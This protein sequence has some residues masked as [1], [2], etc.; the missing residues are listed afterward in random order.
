MRFALLNDH[1]IEASPGAQGVCPGCNADMLARCGAKKVWHWAHKGRRHCDHWWE[2]ETQWHRDWKN[3]FETDWQEVPARDEMGELHIA[4]IK[5]P[6]G[7][8]IEFQHSAIKPDEVVKR[9]NF[10]G[11]VIWIIDGT[12]RPTDLIQY[13]RMLSENYP[14]RFDGVDIYT[15]YCEETRLLK[16]WGSLGKIV[17]FDFGGDNLCLL[18]AAQGRSRYLFDFSKAEFARSIIEGSPLPVVQFA[19]PTQRGYRRRRRF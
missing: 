16:E 2:N 19:K 15:V 14:Q 10:Y 9:T 6:S 11:Q 8:V 17:G 3:R 7:L 1:R 12:R 13:E 18:T 5:T 4:D